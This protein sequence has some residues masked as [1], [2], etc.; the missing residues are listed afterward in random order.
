MARYLTLD[1]IKNQFRFTCPIFNVETQM[2]HCVQLRDMVYYG[3]SAPVRKG[4]QACIKSGKCP[5]SEIVRRISFHRNVPDDYGSVTPV[6]GKLRRDVLEKVHRVIVQDRHL[7]EAQVSDPERLLI[8]SA[9]DR[10][11]K[12]IGAAPLPSDDGAPRSTFESATAAPKKRRSAPKTEKS[13]NRVNEA[14]ASGDLAAA[15]SIGV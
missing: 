5:A 9:S 12:M 14:A 6:T 4:C 8:A 2:R 11:G 1:T 15:V 7:N 13:N 10:I 3:G